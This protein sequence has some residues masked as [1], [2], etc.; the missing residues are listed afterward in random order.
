MERFIAYWPLVRDADKSLVIAWA[1]YHHGQQALA[2][3]LYCNDM[4]SNEGWD[5]ERLTPILAGL[6]E[7]QPWLDQWHNEMDPEKQ[8]RL[9]EFARSFVESE[10]EQLALTA[11]Q[12]RAWRP[13]TQAARAGRR[14]KR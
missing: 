10:L 1:G 8:Q 6:Q 9:N 13:T 7:L 11:E 14:K 12:V 4:R 5:A 2:L 3:A